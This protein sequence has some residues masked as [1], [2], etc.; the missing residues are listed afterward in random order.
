MCK[1]IIP[2][3]LTSKCLKDRYLIAAGHL[4]L[5]TWCRRLVLVLQNEHLAKI[6]KKSLKSQVT[7]KLM[8]IKPIDGTNNADEAPS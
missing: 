5:N 4:A 6:A 1:G 2:I 3:H 7:R 8:S